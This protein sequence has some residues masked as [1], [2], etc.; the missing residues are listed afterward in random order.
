ML[1][2]T[3]GI[4]LHQFKFKDSSNIAKI[5][6]EDYGIKPFI[7]KG[8]RGKSSSLKPQAFQPL[9]LLDLVVWNQESKSNWF[10]IR[11]SGLINPTTT[12]PFDIA[13]SALAVFMAEIILKSVKDEQQDRELFN[14]VFNAIIELDQRLEGFSTFHLSF[15]S[16][17]S[18]LLGFSIAEKHNNQHLANTILNWDQ[19]KSSLLN[20]F[21]NGNSNN[22][23]RSQRNLLLNVFI[24]CYEQNVV[25]K[26]EI[27]S[28][29]IF[30]NLF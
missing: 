13:K 24:E 19:N 11:E 2:K 20:L 27:K 29:K 3:R 17:L 21:F 5:F 18:D 4:F 8:L 6:T 25:Q 26:G 10:Y 15:L 16:R 7:I 23:N 1:S 30:E 28:H 14:Y 22:L 12:I 9:T